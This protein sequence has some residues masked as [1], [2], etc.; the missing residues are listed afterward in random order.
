MEAEIFVSIVIP[1]YNEEDR[2][3]ST[4]EKTIAYLEAQSYEGEIIVVSDGSTDGTVERVKEC[5]G[6]FERLRIVEYS[7]NRG[8]GRAVRTGALEAC[9]KYVLFMDADYSVPLEMI[10]TALQYMEEGYEIAIGSRGMSESR[11]NKRQSFARELAGR[12]Y[13]WIQNA[14]LGLDFADAQCGFKLFSR[15]AAR[16]LFPLQRLD[17]VIYDGEI[18]FLAR[19]AGFEVREFPVEWNHDPESRLRYDLKSSLRVFWEL[20]RIRWL[21]R[22]GARAGEPRAWGPEPP[23]SEPGRSHPGKDCGERLTASLLD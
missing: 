2:I 8:K 21:H 14:W 13:G 18:L 10:E 19:R 16:T 3:G 17:S 6:E 7:P 20:F 5:Q 4:L 22:K 1:A 12:A 11:L 9:G 15:R 23:A